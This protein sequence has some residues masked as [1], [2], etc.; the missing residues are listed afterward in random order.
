MHGEA[1]ARRPERAGEVVSKVFFKLE[2]SKSQIPE[3][4]SI[5]STSFTVSSRVAALHSCLGS[6]C[7]SLPLSGRRVSSV[8][9]LHLAQSQR[10][11]LHKVSGT[12]TVPA[13]SDAIRHC[14]SW[15]IRTEV[16]AESW[17]R[18]VAFQPLP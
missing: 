5:K 14:S 6:R 4:E 1:Q 8:E 11:W 10:Q 3:P 7:P 18:W 13:M 9:P 17:N 12:H 16:T 2:K 15:R